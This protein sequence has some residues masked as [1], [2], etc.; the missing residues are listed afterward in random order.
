MTAK[1]LEVSNLSLDVKCYEF[2]ELEIAVLINIIKAL[3]STISI[4]LTLSNFCFS[5]SI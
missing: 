2:K 5:C 3:L 1:G 4:E